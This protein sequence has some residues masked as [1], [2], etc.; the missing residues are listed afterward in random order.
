MLNKELVQRKINNIENY[1][2][3]IE[4]LLILDVSEI[5]GDV[6]KLR[7]IERNFQL[8]VDTMLDINTHIIS[9]KN[10]KAPETM[11]ETFLILGEAKVLPLDFVK[12]IAPVVGLRN[13]VVHEYEKVDNEKMMS[14][15]KDGASQFGEYIVHIDNFLEKE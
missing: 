13:I 9:A 15:V 14:D 5:A 2:K 6:L 12:K 7:T 10:L 11:Q 4:P 8:I 3:E 1:I